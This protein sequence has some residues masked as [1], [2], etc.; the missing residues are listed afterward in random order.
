[1]STD[2]APSAPKAASIKQRVD[3]HPDPLQRIRAA[4]IEGEN[5]GVLRPL[6]PR[7]FEQRMRRPV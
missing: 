3:A 5:S 4:L 6:D 2:N 7:A 1:M